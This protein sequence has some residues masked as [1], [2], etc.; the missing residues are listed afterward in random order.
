MEV[1]KGQV[2]AIEF[3]PKQTNLLASGGTDGEVLI[4]DLA[5]PKQPSSSKPSVQ[6]TKPNA[7][8]SALSW[9]KKAPQILAS[10]NDLGETTI[11]DLRQRRPVFSLHQCQRLQ[12]RANSLSWN[13]DQAVQ[14]AVCYA[15]VPTAEIWDLRASQTPKFK[16]EGHQASVL[17]VDWCPFDSSLLISTAEDASYVYLPLSVHAL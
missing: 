10:A 17:A 2:Y 14:L 5:N 6:P 7:G 15:G 11:W 4:W 1:H 8:I 13:P 9:N 3:H 16:L 12:T